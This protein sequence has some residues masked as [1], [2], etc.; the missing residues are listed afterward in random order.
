MITRFCS[1]IAFGSLIYVAAYAQVDTCTRTIAV[2]V[3]QK[4]SPREP[5]AVSGLTP[6]D[7]EVKFAGNSTVQSGTFHSGP[8][9]AV[10]LLDIGRNQ[11]R[12]EWESLVAIARNMAEQLPKDSQL[13]LITFSDQVEEVVSAGNDARKLTDSLI[14]MSPGSKKSNQD[15]LFDALDRGAQLFDSARPGDVEVF[16]SPMGKGGSSKERTLGS[17]L[18]ASGVR[19]FGVVLGTPEF[20]GITAGSVPS[21]SIPSAATVT[22][23]PDLFSASERLA[24]LTGGMFVNFRRDPSERQAI[25]QQ[26]DLASAISAF[27]TNYYSLTFV[28]SSVKRA[29]RVEVKLKDKKL[30]SATFL[31]YP[32][33]LYPCP[34]H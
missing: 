14:R 8:T 19:A 32:T 10:F 28:S 30:A 9:R 15:G 13:N 2:G 4:G 3:F 5:Q 1:V 29:E 26:E 11:T 27:V 25:K 34:G 24:V 12:T 22:E 6:A 7:F 23:Y 31:F 16:F 20:P 33:T 18:S 21:Q 17:K